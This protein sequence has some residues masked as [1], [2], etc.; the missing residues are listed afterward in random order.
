[1]AERYNFISYRDRY[2]LKPKAEPLIDKEVSQIVGKKV[3]VNDPRLIKLV[4][5]WRA[6]KNPDNVDNYLHD[7]NKRAELKQVFNS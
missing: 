3:H 7:E 1:M 5:K 2:N 4:I 6:N